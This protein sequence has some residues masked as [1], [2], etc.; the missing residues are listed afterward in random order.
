MRADPF[1]HRPDFDTG[2]LDNKNV[3][4]LPSQLFTNVAA[5]SLPPLDPWERRLLRTQKAAPTDVAGWSAPFH[6]ERGPHGL[7]TRARKII[8][9]ADNALRREVIAA[10]HDHVTAGHSGIS[11]TL[12]AVEQGYW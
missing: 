3:V 11:K 10:H 7:W 9:V 2:A 5:L 12:H 1:S 8:V 4:V 6:L